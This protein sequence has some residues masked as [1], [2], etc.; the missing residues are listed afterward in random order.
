M[1]LYKNHTVVVLNAEGLISP[2][3]LR[4]FEAVTHRCSEREAC[5]AAKDL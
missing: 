1:P 5:S 2:E 4:H 3:P